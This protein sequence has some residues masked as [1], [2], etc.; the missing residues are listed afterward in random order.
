MPPFQL[1]ETRYARS[2]NVSIAYQ[3]MGD[4][5][6]DLIMVPGLLSHIEFFH[7]LAGYTDFLH[8]LAA[9]ARVI[10]F[11]KRGQGLSDRV[12]G[13]PTLDE[14]MDDLDA[15][16]TALGISRAALL[17]LFRGGSDERAVLRDLSRAGFPSHPLRRIC[18]FH[19]L[20]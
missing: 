12:A 13:S 7:E 2:G 20:R 18:P 4:G 9:F 8:R 19:Q 16:M 3:V 11:D 1:P 14:R 5:P 10:S 17:W 6:I 15:V